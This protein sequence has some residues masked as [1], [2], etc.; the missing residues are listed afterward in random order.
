MSG[1]KRALAFIKRR[2]NTKKR[3][4]ELFWSSESHYLEAAI[5]CRTEPLP[6][7]VS[8][9]GGR[10]LERDLRINGKSLMDGQKIGHT[11]HIGLGA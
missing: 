4:T 7:N 8:H 2:K 6:P 9:A 11:V 3:S 1:A 10:V 5:G